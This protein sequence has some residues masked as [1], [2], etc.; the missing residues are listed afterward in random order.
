MHAIP[1]FKEHRAQTFMA[2]P[3][4]YRPWFTLWT[5]SPNSALHWKRKVGRNIALFLTS[6]VKISK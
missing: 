6:V 5:S 3:S 2:R 1:K 4:F